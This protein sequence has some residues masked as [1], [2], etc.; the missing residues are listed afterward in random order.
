MEAPYVPFY[1]PYGM[2]D[3]E[4]EQEVMEAQMRLELWYMEQEEL[5]RLEKSYDYDEDGFCDGFMN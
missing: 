3:E 5:S 1:K 2:S 4:Y